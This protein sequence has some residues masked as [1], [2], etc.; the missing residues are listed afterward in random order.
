MHTY[1]LIISLVSL[2]WGYY[3]KKNIKLIVAFLSAVGLISFFSVLFQWNQ[4]T[5][6][7]EHVK[8]FC[9]F[10][11][12]RVDFTLLFL[13]FLLL[14]ASFKVIAEGL[15]YGLWSK[16]IL[17][18]LF[19]ALFYKGNLLKRDMRAGV[20]GG[21]RGLITYNEYIAEDLFDRIDA[22]IDFK[23][24]DFHLVGIDIDPSAM[25]VN[26]A[27]TLDIYTNNYPL[28]HKE[29]MQKVIQ[30]EYDTYDDLPELGNRC[31]LKYGDEPEND[32]IFIRLDTEQLKKLGCKYVL[33][34]YAIEN[35]QDLNLT[36]VKAY[37]APETYWKNINVY[38]VF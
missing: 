31:Y 34:K 30:G 3:K 16:V 32:E 13:M 25:L 1:I 12:T 26:G 21:N 7:Y 37:P 20:Y 17:T 10:N 8:F 23:S 28:K 22:D 2:I 15:D 5:F 36:F 27:T 38:Q 35:Y 18:V 14:G 33:S 6:L 29:A 4:M 9:M 24:W 19:I 11:A